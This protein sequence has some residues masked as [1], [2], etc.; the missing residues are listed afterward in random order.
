[1]KTKEI[2]LA[3]YG[4]YNEEKDETHIK[5]FTITKEN[6]KRYIKELDYKSMKEFLNEYTWDTT[7]TIYYMAIE[8]N[9]L[10]S[11]QEEL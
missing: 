6:L 4:I 8:E 10:I 5:Y 9:N 3:T 11:E 7:E 2:T 1:M